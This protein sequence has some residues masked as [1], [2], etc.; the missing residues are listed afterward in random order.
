MILS[1]LSFDISLVQ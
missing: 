1:A